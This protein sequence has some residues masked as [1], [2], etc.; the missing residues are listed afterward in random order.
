[1]QSKDRIKTT[2]EAANL[3]E[4]SNYKS[5]LFLHWINLLW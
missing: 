5:L 3:A 2:N 4:N 1:M